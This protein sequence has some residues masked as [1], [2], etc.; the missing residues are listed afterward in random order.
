MRSAISVVT[1]ATKSE[2]SRSTVSAVTR[3]V[4]DPQARK[5]V[6][7]VVGSYEVTR[8][9]VAFDLE[10]IARTARTMITGDDWNRILGDAAGEEV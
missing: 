4:Y 7:G 2:I 6:S 10:I 3:L 9:S 8:Q 1:S 5:E